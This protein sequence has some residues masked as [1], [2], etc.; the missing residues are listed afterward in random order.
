VFALDKLTW[1]NE[2]YIHELS[3]TQLA[4]ALIA[5]RLRKAYLAQLVPLVRQRI[6]RSTTSIPPPSTSSP[7]ISTTPVAAE[8]A[9]PDVAPAD[10][11]KGLLGYVDRIEAREGWDHAALEAEARAW[12]EALGWKAK[13]AFM[14]LRLVVTGRKASPPLFETMAVLGKELTRRR[15]RQAAELI[16][17]L[18]APDARVPARA[19]AGRDDRRRRRALVVIAWDR[20]NGPWWRFVR[21]FTV[22]QWALIDADDGP[23]ANPGPPGSIPRCS[24]S[25]LTVCVSLTLQEYVGQRDT[26]EQWFPSTHPDKYWHL[27]GFVWWTG[28]RVFGYLLLP[29]AVV[30]CLPGERLRDYHWSP[31]GFCQAPVDL[32]RL[33]FAFILPAVIHRVGHQDCSCT[34]TRSIA[35]PTARRSICGRGR[36]C[37]RAVPVARV[38]LPRLHAAGAAPRVRRERDLRDDGAVLHDPLRQADARDLRRDRRRPGARH[39]RDAHALDLGRRADPRRRRVDDGSVR[40]RS[41]PGQGP[42]PVARRG[43]TPAGSRATPPVRPSPRS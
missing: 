17:K 19:A 1:L 11:A 34:P 43:A 33:M 9:V 29:I 8:L 39:R 35:T 20:R 5:W 13:H 3:T 36:R 12:C 30:R 40:G 42:V 14:L 15:L 25:S 24:R 4:D 41:L 7:A 6:K 27:K 38:L 28:W 22:H 32:P 23:G 18:P 31:R 26:Y 37:T 16:G 21:Y 2:K 10:V